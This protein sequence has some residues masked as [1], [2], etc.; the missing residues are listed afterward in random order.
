MEAEAVCGGRAGCDSA[1]RH[2]SAMAGEAKGRG[3]V[4]E[5]G[6]VRC[7]WVIFRHG[8]CATNTILRDGVCGAAGTVAVS[9]SVRGRRVL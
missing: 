4:S 7:D 5:L 6:R 1:G 2:V 8:N 3:V 9:E